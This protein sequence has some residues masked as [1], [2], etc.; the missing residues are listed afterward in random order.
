MNLLE[1]MVLKCNDVEDLEYLKGY[2]I[3]KNNY[4]QKIKRCTHP[5]VYYL[6]YDIEYQET[7]YKYLC[8]ECNQV[9][10]GTIGIKIVPKSYIAC[11]QRKVIA[12]SFVDIYNAL[13]NDNKSIDEV[14]LE[15]KNF[16]D[17]LDK[18]EILNNISSITCDEEINKL[19]IDSYRIYSH[20]KRLKKN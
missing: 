15:L 14:S 2:I 10:E 17:F 3:T 20:I 5:I 4:E 7:N 19:I 12:G 8:L 1:E 13:S 18:K 6:D 11:R 9:V 16:Q